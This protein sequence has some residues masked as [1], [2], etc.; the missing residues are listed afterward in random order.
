MLEIPRMNRI[1]L[2]AILTAVIISLA[3]VWLAGTQPPHEAVRNDL[4]GVSDAYADRLFDD[5]YVHTINLLVPDVNWQF[6]VQHAMEEQYVLCDAEID[7]EM[8]RNIAI[9]PKGNSS[10]A[11]I[12]GAGSDRF[13]FKIEFDHYRP[14]NTYHGLDKLALNNLGQDISCLKDYLTYQM[15]AGMNVPG[16]LCAYTLLQLNGQDFG[17]YLAVEG[18]ED[19]F[20]VR[21]YGSS[22]TGNLYRPDVYAIESLTPAAFIDAPNAE[23]FQL[24]VNTLTPGDRV[25]ALGPIINIAF[26][27]RRDQARISA[28]GY[29]GDD[30][31]TYGVVFDTAVFGLQPGDKPRY[32]NA[33]KMLCT[34][35]DPR[36]ALDVANLCRYFAVHNFVNNYDSYTG[37]F[38]HNY[39]ICEKDGR[40]SLVPWDYN[41]GFGAF[42]AECAYKCFAR[43]S[44]WYQPMD[45]GASMST[46]KS[47]VNYPIDTPLMSATMDERPLL[48]YLIGDAE[49]LA[50]YHAAMDD[51]IAAYFRSGRYQQMVARARRL[52]APYVEQGL[53]FYTAAEFETAAD[54]VAD[55]GRLRAESIEG[56]LAGTI[57]ATMEGQQADYARLVD[58]GSLDLSRTIDFGGL[59]FGITPEEVCGILDA[60]F[61]GYD[62]AD[63]EQLA[64]DLSAEPSR[65]AAL[66]GRLFRSSKLLSGALTKAAAPPLIFIIT[67]LALVIA[68]RRMKRTGGIK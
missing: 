16:P 65:I 37:I 26:A 25:D 2:A 51:F 18:I 66:V 50:L 53:T 59:A 64:A 23:I 24:D 35:G 21:N 47:F 45:M 39:Y 10:L 6:M 17:L 5:S 62:A 67:L 22:W 57:P 61:D 48:R 33:V 11:S 58:T 15:M 56:Q 54:M 7:G 36:S 40:L 44:Q 30:P 3:L 55:Y 19:S 32:M 29:A 31:D 46:E 42:S 8:I 28:G 60:V 13:S 63:V 41:L 12:A 27:A 14:G 20:A 4:L 43:D 9:R 52:I 49:G 68:L 34:S 38:A 1:C